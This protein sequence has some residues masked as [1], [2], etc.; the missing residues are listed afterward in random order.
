MKNIYILIL[1]CLGSFS[2]KA[3]TQSQEILVDTIRNK[4][5]ITSGRMQL[6]LMI[7]REQKKADASD[8][9]HDKTIGLDED[10]DLVIETIS[11]RKIHIIVRSLSAI[12]KADGSIDL[13][14]IEFILLI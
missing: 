9:I 3:Q 12:I 1:F 4:S 11:G 10:I 13:T 6:L 5:Q 14:N 2:L 7:E 8:G